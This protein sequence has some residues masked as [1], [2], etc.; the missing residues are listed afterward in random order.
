MTRLPRLL[1]LAA[2][3]FSCCASLSPGADNETL[4]ADLERVYGRWRSAMITQNFERWRETTASYRQVITRNAIVSRKELF[5]SNLFKIP[6][7]PPDL[8]DLRLIKF[9]EKNDT[10]VCVYFGKID[11]GIETNDIPDNLL[12]LRFL[13]EDGAWRYDNSRFV[14]LAGASFV[15]EN[16]ANGDFEFLKDEDFAPLGAVPPAGKLCPVPDFAAHIHIIS[17]GYRT[18]AIVNDIHQ[19]EVA[20]DGDTGIIT[21]GLITGKNSIKIQIEPLELSEKAEPDR[22]FSV[23]I[24]AL[25][26]EENKPPVQVF[27]LDPETLPASVDTTFIVDPA[28]FP[29]H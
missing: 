22:Q 27:H 9:E 17:I 8:K 21:G 10:A 1:P 12:V 6:L 24:Y 16:V 26:R 2:I 14:N 11:Y 15:R 18:T 3:G 4:R 5:P 23:S 25:R 19:V 29:R 13:F 20:Q 7:T 28:T